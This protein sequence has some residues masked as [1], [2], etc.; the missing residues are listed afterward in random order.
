MSHYV[1]HRKRIYRITYRHIHIEK[2]YS[3]IIWISFITVILIIFA[4]AI[5]FHYKLNITV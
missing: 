4:S 5:Y 2:Q 1:H 3:L